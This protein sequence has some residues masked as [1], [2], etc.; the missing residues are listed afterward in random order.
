MSE[1]ESVIIYSSVL[2]TIIK[3]AFSDGMYSAKKDDDCAKQY[4]KDKAE[5]VRRIISQGLIV[6]YDDI[7]TETN[8][9]EK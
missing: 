1:F 8:T 6:R 9:E 7:N 5:W 3:G 4:A 2:E